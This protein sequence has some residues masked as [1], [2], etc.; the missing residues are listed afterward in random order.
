MPENNAAIPSPPKPMDRAEAAGLP[1]DS[2]PEVEVIR[3]RPSLW[4]GH[5]FLSTLLLVGPI[6][7]LIALPILGFWALPVSFAVAGGIALVCWFVLFVW[8]LRY[9]VAQSLWISNKRVVERRGLLSR[10]LNEVLHDHVRNIQVKQSFVQRVFGIGSIGI[11]SAGQDGIEISM[12]NLPNPDD[13][14]RTID[15]YRPL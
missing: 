9:S 7:G 4:R 11:S 6:A 13:I 3:I 2:G 14:K 15:L 12:K 10:S 1:P 8:W 5:P